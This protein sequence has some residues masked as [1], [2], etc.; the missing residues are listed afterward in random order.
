MADFALAEA[1]ARRQN[2]PIQSPV[3]IAAEIGL[4]LG[5]ISPISGS[6]KS[7]GWLSKPSF[8]IWPGQAPQGR[9]C[10]SAADF[11]QTPALGPLEESPPLG[12]RV[13][14]TYPSKFCILQTQYKFLPNFAP[15][16]GKKQRLPV[17]FQ[18]WKW[19]AS[20]KIRHFFDEK[21]GTLFRRNGQKLIIFWSVFDRGSPDLPRTRFWT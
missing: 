21:V 4:K 1:W 18:F 11:S 7:R 6:W 8:P 16:I 17:N 5:A 10:G 13:S 3:A 2:R 19:L 20:E 12:P 14:Q 15:K 9:H